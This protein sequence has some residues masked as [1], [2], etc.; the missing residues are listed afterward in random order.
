MNI[1]NSLRFFIDNS[2]KKNKQIYLSIACNNSVDCYYKTIYRC[3]IEKIK[4]EKLYH[5]YLR[6][7]PFELPIFEI[8]LI[9]PTQ[10]MYRVNAIVLKTECHMSALIYK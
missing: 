6:I 2:A 5:L 7:G 1:C 8:K 10:L 4:L 3:Q 9:E